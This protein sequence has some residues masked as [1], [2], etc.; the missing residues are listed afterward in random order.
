MCKAFVLRSVRDEIQIE[1][2]T[3]FRCVGFSKRW[4]TVVTAH[5][6]QHDERPFPNQRGGEAIL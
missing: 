5:D 2:P 4:P 3:N 1:P 6:D